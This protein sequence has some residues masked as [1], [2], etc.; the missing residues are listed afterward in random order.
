MLAVEIN[1]TGMYRENTQTGLPLIISPKL[2]ESGQRLAAR[3]A[4]HVPPDLRP[5]T[6]GFTDDI[7]RSIT[8]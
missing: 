2:P 1:E 4:Q 3:R 6:F 7:E 5:L 8:R